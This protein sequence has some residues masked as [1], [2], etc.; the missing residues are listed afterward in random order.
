MNL[1]TYKEQIPAAAR[2]IMERLQ[3]SGYE[4]YLVGG[5][6]RDLIL[7]RQ[8]GDY[9]ITTNALPEET[10]A[11]FRDF[12][13]L[14]IGKA[15]GT[16]GVIVDHKAYEVTTYRVDGEYTDHRRPDAVTFTR[17]LE[18]DLERRDFRINAVAMDLNGNLRG[19][20]GY[21]ED[22]AR[23][24]ICAVGN[25][26]QRFEE[27]ALRI[28][29]GVRFA[30]QLG[31]EIEANTGRAIHEKKHLL[32]QIS[33]ERIRVEIEK[34]LTAPNPLPVLREY[35]DVF[36][37]VIPELRETFDFN[38]QN[39]FHCYDVYEHILHV[40]GNV[41]PEP[42]LRLAA[43]FHDIGKPR[44]FVVKENWGHFYGHEQVSAEMAEAI[45][46]RL[47]YDRKTVKDVTE[48]VASHGYVFNRTEKYVRRRLNQLGEEQLMRLIDLERGDVLSQAEHVR[49]E[50]AAAI[51]AFR[52]LVQTVAEKE[53]VLKR[54]DL[55][56]DGRD[57]L[58]L[59][60]PRGPEVGRVLDEILDRVLEGDLE[61]RREVLLEAA[62]EW[63]KRGC[64]I[65]NK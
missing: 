16:I 42:V 7:G 14:E 38:Q 31:Y 60:V 58:E 9:D 65:N 21:E 56:I 3:A 52:E 40:V 49:K 32:R 15:H 23:R 37:E 57:V 10:E 36:A 54:K 39:P 20:P 19:A 59:G 1:K 2:F 53:G 64:R 29:R 41:P 46:K 26:V 35:R 50:R 27:D 5:A 8:P 12:G 33:P 47:R 11:V 4:A 28:L 43:L 13:T 24:Q 18:Q 34:T 63:K 51:D 6:V 25:P 55:A 45:L 30:A 61:N 22:F 17:S 44:C 48:L 62:E